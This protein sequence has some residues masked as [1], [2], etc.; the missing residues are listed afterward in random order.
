MSGNLL[1]AEWINGKA[2]TPKKMPNVRLKSTDNTIDMPVN[3]THTNGID[4]NYSIDISSIDVSKQYYLEAR[5]TGED[6][7]GKN[8]TQ[9]VLLP[10]KTIGTLK[11]REILLEDNKIKPVY[12]GEINTDLKTINLARNEVGRNYIYGEILIAEWINGV[13][14]V[15]LELPEMTI[16]A[17]DGSFSTGIHV[18]HNGGLSYTYD[19]VI[20]NLDTS[21]EYEIEI[22][23]N[24]INNKGTKK[25]QI[26]KLPD[27]E[28]GTYE[29]IKLVAQNNRLK[30][31]DASLYKGDINTDLQTM[32]IG[33]NEIGRE[34]IY[35]NIL[36]AEWIDG[37]ANTPNGVPEM[38]LKAT[39]G[40]YSMGMHVSHVGG[41]RYYY[42]RVIYDLDVGKE[43]YI[44]VKLTGNKNIG[45]NK[46]QVANLNTGKN[47]GIL[48]DKNL[49]IENNKIVFK[50]N[51]YRGEINTDLKTINLAQNEIGRNYIYGEILIAE[52]IDGIACI[53]NK[54]PEMTIKATDGSFRTGMHVVHNGGLSY[55]YDRV[56][57]NLDNSKEYEIEVKLTN[58]N[59]IAT[60][61]EQIAKIPNKEIG[62][63]GDIKLLAED[64]KIKMKDGSK[65][66]GEINTDLKTMYID[67]NEIGREYIHGNILIAEWIDG[68]ANTPKGLPEMTLKATD[69]SYSM[70]MH[71]VHEGGLNYYYDRVVY[72]LDI[73]KEYYIE[74]KLTNKNNISTHKVQQANIR[75]NEDIGI[76]KD[77][78]KIVLRNNKMLFEIIQTRILTIQRTEERE[79]K[80][81]EEEIE[82]EIEEELLEGEEEQEEEK[83][84]EEEKEEEGVIEDP[85]ILEEKEEQEDESIEKI[86]ENKMKEKQE[87]IE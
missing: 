29:K 35:G 8:K 78:A 27:K 60:K 44:E 11:G 53:P 83:E 68:V 47:I 26:A 52:W 69:G 56:M 66:E 39:D 30:M 5:L 28:I 76:F 57:D 85:N 72:D 48:K 25:S 49:T 86:E 9:T 23:L 14:N 84:K 6:N 43:Y 2:Q 13:A 18:V 63:Y 41:L 80:V 33:V 75:P 87:E 46:T 3:I 16:K 45:T 40:S 34:Y 24:E 7:I 17:I 64:N 15:P 55:T 4:Y 42:D 54:L 70:G 62:R 12:V 20:D 59:N 31:I 77:K 38:T 32:Y 58:N 65:Y 50:G 21:K 22:K 36:I 19:R 37:V 82:N 79:E 81:K 51:E 71:V 67:F 1:I 61:K 73:N 10:N 74:V